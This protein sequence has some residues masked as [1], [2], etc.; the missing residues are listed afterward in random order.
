MRLSFPQI[1]LY[2]VLFINSFSS[3]SSQNLINNASFEDGLMGWDIGAWG[4]A[5]LS[6]SITDLM[7][8]QGA[9]AAEFIIEAATPGEPFKGY[10]RKNGLPLEE[11]GQY[12]LAFDIRSASGNTEK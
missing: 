2:V 5:E 10:A 1:S 8:S 3:I 12:V 9:M 11:G 7:A 6:A 4:G